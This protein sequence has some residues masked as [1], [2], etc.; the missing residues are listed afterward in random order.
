MFAK[1]NLTTRSN[2]LRLYYYGVTVVAKL[3]RNVYLKIH[4]CLSND[5]KIF[6]LMMFTNGKKISDPAPSI[7]SWQGNHIELVMQILIDDRL[8]L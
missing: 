6:K 3:F 2:N 7:F 4:V 8:T 5:S 1:H